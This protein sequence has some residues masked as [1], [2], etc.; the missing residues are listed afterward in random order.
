MISRGV[1]QGSVLGPWLWNL[2]YDPILSTPVPLTVRSQCYADDLVLYVYAS[3]PT[4]MT[5]AMNKAL[6]SI[7]QWLSDHHL[8]MAAK[9]YAILYP[10]I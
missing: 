9:G 2:V 1:P 10:G 4:T 7:T 5:M 8:E 3:S 6:A